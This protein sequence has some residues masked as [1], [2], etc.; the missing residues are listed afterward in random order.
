VGDDQVI[1][2]DTEDGLQKAIY[3]LEIVAKAYNLR[4][5]QNKKNQ[6][7]RPLKGNME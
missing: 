1:I 6:N 5:P 7:P 2:S 3:L 4:F